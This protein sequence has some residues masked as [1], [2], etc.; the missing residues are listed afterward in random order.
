MVGT[1]RLERYADVAPPGEGPLGP[2]PEGVLI[3]TRDG[4]VSVSMMRAPAPPGAEVAFMGYAGT[5]RLVGTD[6]VVHDVLVASHAHLPGTA[7]VR[8]VELDGDRLT[9]AGVSRLGGAPRGRVLTWRRVG[10][11]G[12]P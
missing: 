6:R 9:L 1:W 3:Y 12:R 8:D 4:H 7:Q 10:G 11:G 2:T 5:W